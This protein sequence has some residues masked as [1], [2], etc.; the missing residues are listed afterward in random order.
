[1]REQTV[2]GIAVR[3]SAD[4]AEAK[5][6]TDNTSASSMDDLFTN[7]PSQKRMR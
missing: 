4:W 5:P 7:G 3:A 1:M 2:H 6:H